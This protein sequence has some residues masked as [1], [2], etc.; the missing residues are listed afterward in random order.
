ME[1]INL[2]KY[3]GLEGSGILSRILYTF[4]RKNAQGTEDRMELRIRDLIRT[5]EDSRWFDI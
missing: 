2:S 1:E 4:S 5:A 3:I